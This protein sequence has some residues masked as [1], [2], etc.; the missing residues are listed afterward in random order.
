MTIITELGI[1]LTKSHNEKNKS[2]PTYDFTACGEKKNNS[3]LSVTA[4]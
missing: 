3:T 1:I 2:Y 4:K